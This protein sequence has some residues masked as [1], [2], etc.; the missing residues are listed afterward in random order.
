MEILRHR[1]E[2]IRY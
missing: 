2:E 1:I